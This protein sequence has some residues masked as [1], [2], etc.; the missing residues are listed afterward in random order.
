MQRLEKSYNARFAEID[1]LKGIAIALVVLGHVLAWFYGDFL[2]RAETMSYNE[3]VLWRYVYSF[4]MPLFMFVSGFVVFNPL[5]KYSVKQVF[6]RSMSYIIPLLS[7]GVLCSAYREEFNI[8]NIIGQYWY[9]KTLV[10]F[11]LIVFLVS[12]LFQRICKCI[13]FTNILISLIFMIIVMSLSFIGKRYGRLSE[14]S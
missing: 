12:K 6:I 11:L 9:F 14:N 5:K 8:G 2:E 1:V 10:I 4:H 7:W 13:L 3:M